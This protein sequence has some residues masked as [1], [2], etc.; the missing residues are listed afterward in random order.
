MCLRNSPNPRNHSLGRQNRLIDLRLKIGL[1][2]ARSCHPTI[3][4]EITNHLE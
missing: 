4:K 2:D 3:T 1:N